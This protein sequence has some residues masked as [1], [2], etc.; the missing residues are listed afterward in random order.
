MRI[1]HWDRNRIYWFV[2]YLQITHACIKRTLDST[3]TWHT[4]PKLSSLLLVLRKTCV[5]LSRLNDVPIFFLMN[6]LI[7]FSYMNQTEYCYALGALFRNLFLKWRKYSAK[8]YYLKSFGL[9]LDM[10]ILVD[11]RCPC[12]TP[13]LTQTC[14]IRVTFTQWLNPFTIQLTRW[15]LF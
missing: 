5:I 11:R 12:G 6:I 4:R 14:V 8:L 7:Q 3:L 10:Q 13:L 1:G 2:P 9:K 15:Y